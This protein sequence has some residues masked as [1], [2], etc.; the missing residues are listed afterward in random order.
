MLDD[1]CGV[2]DVIYGRGA[3]PDQLERRVLHL[4][5]PPWVI[6]TSAAFEYYWSRMLISRGV[7]THTST[8]EPPRKTPDTQTQPDVEPDLFS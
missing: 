5:S 2:L 4:A 3:E 7:G 6:P 1:I 8:F